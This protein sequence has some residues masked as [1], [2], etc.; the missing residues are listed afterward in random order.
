MTP[1]AVIRQ[2]EAEGRAKASAYQTPYHWAAG[3]CSDGRRASG[4]LPVR[5]AAGSATEIDA[6]K[7]AMT[8]SC[9]DQSRLCAHR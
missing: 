9:R 1:G 6:S 7:T 2:L 8:R 3:L 5:H 4:P